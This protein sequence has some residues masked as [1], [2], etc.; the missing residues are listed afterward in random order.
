MEDYEIGIEQTPT[1]YKHTL[2][3]IDKERLKGNA[4][5]KVQAFWIKGNNIIAVPVNHITVVIENPEKFGLTSE[6]IKIKYD[7]YDEPYNHEGK[8]RQEIMSDLIRT[9]GWIRVRYTFK[10]DL[11]TIECNKLTNRVKDAILSFFMLLTGHDVGEQKAIDK[12]NSYS[13]VR[14]NELYNESHNTTTIKDILHLKGLFESSMIATE[15]KLILIEDYQ[16]NLFSYNGILDIL[17]G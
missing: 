13:D 8:A 4:K 10:N 6:Y 16:T 15:T 12:M 5:P 1:G 14:I 17:R 11:W 2:S 3:P 7:E 9:N